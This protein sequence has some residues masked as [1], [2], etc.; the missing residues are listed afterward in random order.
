MQS[1]KERIIK[2]LILSIRSNNYISLLYISWKY[3]LD[4]INIINFNDKDYI[5]I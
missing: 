2:L 3:I 1:D 4:L 5:L